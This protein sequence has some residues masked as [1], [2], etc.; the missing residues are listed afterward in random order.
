[1]LHP[2]A[3]GWEEANDEDAKVVR[4]V[5]DDVAAVLV[6]AEIIADVVDLAAHERS[7][8]EEQERGL[9]LRFVALRYFTWV[10]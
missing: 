10:V 1:M 5:E 3:A 6:S 9:N 4:L 2:V 8:G 7:C